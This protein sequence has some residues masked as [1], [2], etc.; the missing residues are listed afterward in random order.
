MNPEAAPKVRI[1]RGGFCVAA[2]YFVV[3][4]FV[5]AYTSLTTTPKNVGY[6]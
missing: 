3:V 6:D 4:V 2:F 5:Y 1:N